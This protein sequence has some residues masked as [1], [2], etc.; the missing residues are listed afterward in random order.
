MILKHSTGFSFLASRP[1]KYPANC[2]EGTITRVKVQ[3]KETKTNLQL[4]VGL[5]VLDPQFPLRL[6]VDEEREAGCLGD[7]DAVLN[8][9]VIVRKSLWEE[10][11]TRTEAFVSASL[12]DQYF[13]FVAVNG[14]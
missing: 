7:D 11:Q 10:R 5:F 14:A 6:G 9:E 13:Q 4:V 12:K 1:C 3:S 2:P 8:G